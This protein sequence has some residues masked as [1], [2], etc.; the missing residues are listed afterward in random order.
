[1]TQEVEVLV[2]ITFDVNAEMSYND[3]QNTLEVWI[4]DVMASLDDAPINDV[5]FCQS[6]IISIKEEAEIYGNK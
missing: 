3:I 1:M 5:T 2:K 6:E 4:N